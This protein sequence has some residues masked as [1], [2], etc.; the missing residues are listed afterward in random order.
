[1]RLLRAQFA[2][3]ATRPPVQSSWLGSAS[4]LAFSPP[5]TEETE[6]MH[7]NSPVHRKDRTTSLRHCASGVVPY[8]TSPVA[9][10]NGR[11]RVLLSPRIKQQACVAIEAIANAAGSHLFCKRSRSFA[12]RHQ[13][14]QLASDHDRREKRSRCLFLGISRLTFHNC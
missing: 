2:I 13:G 1:M 3:C 8:F 12:F 11:F 14:L 10:V 9:C 5:E 7:A 4:M 6:S